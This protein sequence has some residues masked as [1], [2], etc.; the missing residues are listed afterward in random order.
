MNNDGIRLFGI[1]LIE[2]ALKCIKLGDKPSNNVWIKAHR[3]DA[4]RDAIMWFNERHQ[5]P[6]GYGW[7][8]GVSGGNPNVIRRSIIEMIGDEGKLP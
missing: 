8:L 3:I 1:G 5:T 6:G 2:D 4:K 7:C